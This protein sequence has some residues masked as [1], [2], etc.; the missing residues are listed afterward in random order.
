MDDS[1][2]SLTPSSVAQLWCEVVTGAAAKPNR[3]VDNHCPSF[4]D[5]A[6]L[7]QALYKI[8]VE[9]VVYKITVEHLLYFR[10]DDVLSNQE[11]IF[12]FPSLDFL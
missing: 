10:E 9:L 4:D 2:L 8:T 12:S 11:K 6:K 1:L 5:S 7:L 3:N